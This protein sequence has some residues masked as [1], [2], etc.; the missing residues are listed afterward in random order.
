MYKDF[1]ACSRLWGC[2]IESTSCTRY[3]LSCITLH[4]WEISGPHYIR[5]G[6][7]YTTIRLRALI[8]RLTKN[9]EDLS[10]RLRHQPA[11]LPTAMYIRLQQLHPLGLATLPQ[12]GAAGPQQ[13]G[14]R[15]YV[16]SATASRAASFARWVSSCPL[17]APICCLLYVSLATIQS[18]SRTGNPPQACTA[19]GQQDRLMSA[20]TRQQHLERPAHLSSTRW[21]PPCALEAATCCLADVS[22]ALLG[23]PSRLAVLREDCAVGA[24]RMAR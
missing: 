6:L 19:R 1:A 15:E 18:P 22:L 11:V 8:S 4:V 7:L 24:S 10:V 20:Y 12:E 21:V 14:L 2:F 9:D 5:T 3:R 23:P 13:D 17:E 16:L